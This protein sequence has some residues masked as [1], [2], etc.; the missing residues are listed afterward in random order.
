MY[1]ARRPSPDELPSTGEL[2]RSTALA[3][4]AA[5]AILVTVVLPAEYGIDPTGA[6]RALGLT[7]M[8]EIKMALAAE[9]EADRIAQEEAERRY[10]LESGQ[11]FDLVIADEAPPVT[12][13]APAAA[14]APVANPAT[15]DA[16]APAAD[17][18]AAALEAVAAAEAERLARASPVEVAP[19]PAPEPVAPATPEWTDSIS[20]TLTPGEGIEYKLVMEEGAVAEFDWVADGG[21]VNF[22]LHGD[23]S[24]RSISY[25][26]GRAVPAAA[27]ALEAAFTGNHGWFWRN[28]TEANVTVTLR[29][30][31]R[32]TEL[33]RTG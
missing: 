12:A 32:Y 24:G 9:A 19:V 15:A 14:A 26:K 20:F 5:G 8:G 18:I 23:G 11:P 7:E 13:P 21:V 33:K 4:V 3:L 30:R 28:R 10:E 27:G 6:G 2:L 17:P 22:D 16:E 25:E 31:G 1:N 29:V